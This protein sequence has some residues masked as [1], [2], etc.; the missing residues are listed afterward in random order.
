MSETPTLS[1]PVVDLARENDSFRKVVW[2]GDK[3]QLVLMAIPAGG[4]IG[5][6][7]H[8]GHDQLL[9]FVA[10]SGVARIGET[11][12]EVGEGDVS[13]VPSGIFHN[14]RNTGSGILKLFTTYSPPEHEPGTEHATKSEAD[15]DA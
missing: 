8:E 1:L 10:G 9:Y 12:C 6:E 14:I 3:T 4:E 2:T 15:T 5:G 11:E 13:I 7:V